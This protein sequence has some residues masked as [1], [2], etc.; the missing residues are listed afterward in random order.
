MPRSK[1]KEREILRVKQDIL[2]SAAKIFARVGYSG[3]T[4]QEIGREAGYSAPSLYAYFEGKEAI[5]VALSA[6]FL[7][8]VIAVFDEPLPQSLTLEQGM[9]LLMRRLLELCDKRRA[10]LIVFFSFMTLR[11]PLP[12]HGVEGSGHLGNGNVIIDRAATWLET[13]SSPGELGDHSPEDAATF[14][15][16]IVYTFFVRWLQSGAEGR[17]TELLPLTL[18]LFLNG[19]RRP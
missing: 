1:R 14:M 2:D 3:A 19:V 7:T 4:M 17:L 11:E 18:D 12:L 13:N 16:G 9:E 10:A 5:L 15:F 8:E 6:G